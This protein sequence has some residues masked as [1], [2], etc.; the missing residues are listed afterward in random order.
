MARIRN[1]FLVGGLLWAVIFT[2]S[3]GYSQMA[4]GDP[5]AVMTPILMTAEAAR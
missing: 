3:P 1:W 2:V 5:G 4:P